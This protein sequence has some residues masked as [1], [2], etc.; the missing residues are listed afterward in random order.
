MGE[1]LQALFSASNYDFS[2]F[3]VPLLAVGSLNWLLGLATLR[4][5]RGSLPSRTLF[6]MTFVIGVWLLAL[7]GANAATD[8][9]A[10]A[11][12]VK[13]SMLGTVFVPVCAFTHA[14]AGSSRFQSLRR[15]ILAGAILST[16]LAVLVCTTDLVL[17]DTHHYFWGYYPIYGALGPVLMIYYG[18][19][20]VA[21]RAIYRAG[22]T[23]TQSETQRKR[24]RLRQLALV[25][26]MPAAVDFLPTL[27]VAIYPFGYAF[28]LGYICVSTFSIWKYRLIDITPAL[29]AKQV[30]GTMVEGLLVVDRDGFVRVANDAAAQLCGLGRQ[31]VGASIEELDARW[32]AGALAGLLDPDQASE[33]EIEFEGR[34]PGDR[35]SALIVSSKLLDHL[36]AWVG[37]VLIIHDITERAR[38]ERAVRES[39]ERFRSLVQ[40]AS[41][42]ITVI[43]PDTTILYQSPGIQRVLGY[44]ADLTLGRRL[45]DFLNADDQPRFLALLAQLMTKSGESVGGEGRVRASNGQWRVPRVHRHGP[46]RTPPSAA[47][48]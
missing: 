4:R 1:A 36:G 3:A 31:L 38:A 11:A 47:S 44:D 45:L 39:E 25:M 15:Y 32:S 8:P 2:W 37:T 43:A 33:S 21:G 41:D 35:G 28:I 23:K 14:A 29:A 40:H 46:A 20:F 16:A 48:C 6:A 7:G 30:I 22:E 10:G 26:A 24:M 34:T 27:H 18:G 12:F 17:A 9:S 19:F 42:L 13:L 5:E